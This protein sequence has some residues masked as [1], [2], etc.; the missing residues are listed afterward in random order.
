[1]GNKKL[2]GP[3]QKTNPLALGH[4]TRR[5]NLEEFKNVGPS[6][7]ME[8]YLHIWLRS[9]IRLRRIAMRKGHR[10]MQFLLNMLPFLLCFSL[11][12]VYTH[13]LCS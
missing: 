1:M 5:Q 13:Y 6:R 2:R 3:R 10:E 7:A 8:Q 9:F 12:H 11:F 4:E